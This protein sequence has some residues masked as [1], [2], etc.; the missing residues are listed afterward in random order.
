MTRFKISPRK[1]TNRS[2]DSAKLLKM[3]LNC[4]CAYRNLD[5]FGNLQGS[6]AHLKPIFYYCKDNKADSSRAHTT[7]NLSSC[8]MYININ[9]TFGILYELVLPYLRDEIAPQRE[10]A[11]PV[12]IGGFRGGS[13]RPVIGPSGFEQPKNCL[14]GPK[15]ATKY[16]FA[17]V[18][19]P[20]PFPHNH[21]KSRL[22]PPVD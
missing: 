19:C 1:Q 12:A 3:V 22:D 16:V 17:T 4:V 5:S 10:V 14:F 18:I 13:S 9:K 7:L 15:S 6:L 11:R 21:F 20:P 2:L 8:T